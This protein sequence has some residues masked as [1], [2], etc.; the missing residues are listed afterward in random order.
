MNKEIDLN[1]L[2]I[3]ILLNK[4]RQLKPV[5]RATGKSEASI[6]K[7]LAKL[8]E[9]LND[10]LF[11]R[12]PH[13]L[14]PTEYLQRQLPKITEALENLN[15]CLIEENFIPQLYHKNITICLPQTAQFSFG[16]MLADDLIKIFPKSQI[17][18][19]TNS[20]YTTE[21]IILGKVDA[22]LHY[23]NDELPKAIHQ[24]FIGY[25]PA[26]VVTPNELGI[27]T[28]EEAIKLPFIMLEISGW[29]EKEQIIKRALESKGIAINRVA[30]LDNVNSVLKLIR[31]LKAATVL[32]EYQS[33]IEDYQF[34]PVPESY[35]PNGWPKVVIQMKQNHRHNALHQILTKAIAKYI[36]P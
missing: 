4:Y 13:F 23:F 34:I 24:E 17:S 15:N 27:E 16:H 20:E 30:S 36:K 32:L 12:H 21:D 9:Q 7:Y 5:A 28:L 3:L 22:Q 29:K 11:I 31:K 18:I 35:Y 2:K 10:E 19:S 26:V 33:P 25:S 1:L 8:R 6:S 14:E